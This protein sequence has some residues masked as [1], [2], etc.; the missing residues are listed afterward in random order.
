[1]PV[2]TVIEPGPKGKGAVAFGLDWP[3][4]SRGAKTADLALRRRSAFH[5]LDHAWE[6]EDKDLSGQEEA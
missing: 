1:M 4:W 6:M 5:A 2:R 3:G